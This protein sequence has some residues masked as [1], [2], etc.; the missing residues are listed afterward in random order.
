MFAKNGHLTR[1]IASYFTLCIIAQVNELLGWA[2]KAVPLAKVGVAL[3]SIALKV[4][5][6]LAIPS[7]DFQ[8][9]LGTIAGN[10]LSEL[11]KETLDSGVDATAS[12]A[13]ERLEDMTPAE[14][15]DHAGIQ[16][17]KQFLVRWKL[18]AILRMLGFCG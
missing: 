13:R 8:A 9:A 3:A 17:V 16:K 15:L 12:V 10:T 2:K 4:C 14:R 1:E 7:A 11:V 5:T 6:G 18:S